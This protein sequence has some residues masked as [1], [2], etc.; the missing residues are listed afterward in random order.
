MQAPPHAVCQALASPASSPPQTQGLDLHSAQLHSRLDA[1]VQL[2]IQL[3]PRTIIVAQQDI[4]VSGWLIVCTR[5][6]ECA[7][8]K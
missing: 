3:P 6:R 7:P 1:A 5:Q 8:G 2:Y 4:G